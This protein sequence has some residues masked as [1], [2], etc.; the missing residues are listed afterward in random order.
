[1][2]EQGGGKFSLPP[3][4]VICCKSLIEHLKL[5]PFFTTFVFPDAAPTLNLGSTSPVPSGHPL[6]SDG[7]GHLPSVEK[8]ARTECPT[9][10]KFVKELLWL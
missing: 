9:F 10:P 8:G 1:M 3:P 4:R 2:R 6:P 5:Y 7:R